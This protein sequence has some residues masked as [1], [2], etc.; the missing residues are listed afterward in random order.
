MLGIALLAASLVA[1]PLQEGPP[2][3]ILVKGGKTK[4]G[5]TPDQVEK[6]IILRN[7]LRH[8][9]AAQTPQHSAQVDSFYLMPTEVTNEQYA[10]YVKAT[11]A[12]PPRSWGVGALRAGQAAFLEEQGKAKQE[13][14]A[15]GKPFDTTVF[16]P[17]AWWEANW[18]E[19]PWEIQQ[20]EGSHPVVFVTYSDAQGY[21]RWAGLRLMTEFEFQR[22]ARG[23]SARTFPWGEDWDDR[24]FCQSLHIG[25]D[26]TVPVG[27]FPE[28]AVDGL[29]DLA[30][31]VWEWTSSPFIQYPG[32]KQLRFTIDR[33]AVECLAPFDPNQRV[34]VSG[35][36][37]M[38]KNAVRLATRMNAD[39]IQ[40][41]SALGFR[42]AATAVDPNTGPG[43]DAAQ[44]IIERNLK[45]STMG[46]AQLAPRLTSAL[47]KWT[48][49]PGTV[50]VPGYAVITRYEQVLACPREDLRA[51][52]P[53]DL[54]TI[55]SR[56][57]PIFLGFIDVARPMSRP[58][59][60]AGTYFIAWRGAGK[61]VEAKDDK[62]GLLL[63]GQD[64]TT[65]PFH[66]VQGFVAD[67]DCF[68]FYSPEGLP[69][70]AIEAPPVRSERWQPGSIQVEP[71]VAPDPA[72]LPKG[73]PPPV[74]IDTLR[75]KLAIQSASSKSKA[76]VFEL[77]IL[78]APGV[79][80]ASWK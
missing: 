46:D 29:Y 24:K 15:A 2:G 1:V 19:A 76:F 79:Y 16:D 25:K 18:R 80:D 27:S 5:S 53:N 8:H 23:D 9:L 65:T 6:L 31:N 64:D 37:Q 73:A 67:K 4:V 42:C 44:W 28:G 7:D 14:K 72:K 17:E 60:D 13:A 58:E 75:I 38:D 51:S 26:V 62:Q 36:Y 20:S 78:V 61:L 56:E 35:S 59:L 34:L 74:P 3:L 57:G 55:T 52:S 69:Q 71:F 54:G 50:D 45:V 41:T 48:S 49:S 70:L 40:S 10:E 30:G 63:A 77:P 22:A 32:Y 68:F 12:K 11:A 43:M 47:R 21:A 39:R 66:Q 33:R